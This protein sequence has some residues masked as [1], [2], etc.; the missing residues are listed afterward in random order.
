[1]SGAIRGRFL[2][3]ARIH[4]T[5]ETVFEQAARAQRAVV[6]RAEQMLQQ[7]RAAVEQVQVRIRE[8]VAGRNKKSLTGA[9]ELTRFDLR[10]SALRA[11]RDQALKEVEAAV[12]QLARD[13]RVYRDL[14][15]K[16]M[17]EHEFVDVAMSQHRSEKRKHEQKT[18]IALEESIA[19]SMS[20]P[21]LSLSS[22]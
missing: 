6:Q 11:S 20:R 5:R 19:D 12:D 2:P 17:R 4:R 22:I 7:K 16:V 15:K 1:M 8:L 21:V 13:Q 14:M 18:E 3:I 9:D 10:M